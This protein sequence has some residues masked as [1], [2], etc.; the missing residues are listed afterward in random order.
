M[1]FITVRQLNQCLYLGISD[2]FVIIASLQKEIEMNA[3]CFLD[4]HF[5]AR[6]CFVYAPDS[7]LRNG[8]EKLCILPTT[9]K[10]DVIALQQTNGCNYDISPSDVVTWLRELEA[11][12]P[13]ILTCIAHDTLAGRFLTAITD[14]ESLA[15]RMY[16]FCSDIVDQDCGSVEI[17]A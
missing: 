17:L 11:E 12:Q 4:S 1:F 9:D 15:E 10:Y 16:E 2:R 6:G 8:P 14:P 13:F 7:Y 5:L 3:I